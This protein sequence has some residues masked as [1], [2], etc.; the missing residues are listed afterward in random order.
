MKDDA[1]YYFGVGVGMVCSSIL[2][3]FVIWASICILSIDMI[4][5]L[6]ISSTLLILFGLT[7][8]LFAIRMKNKLSIEQ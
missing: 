2:I 1:T 4:L 5:A 6:G 7:Y 3:G 8:C